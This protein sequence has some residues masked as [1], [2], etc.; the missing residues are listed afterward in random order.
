MVKLTIDSSQ[1]NDLTQLRLL[2]HQYGNSSEC[3]FGENSDGESQ[4]ISIC[5]DSVVI[6]THQKNN[7]TRVNAYYYDGTS[8]EYYN[9]EDVA[10]EEYNYG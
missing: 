1:L 9:F 10:E 7:W 3:Y 2:M 5:P 6:Q 8:E 4:R